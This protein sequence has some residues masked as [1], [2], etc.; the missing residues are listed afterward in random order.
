MRD[1][2]PLDGQSEQMLQRL[3]DE[4]ESSRDKQERGITAKHTDKVLAQRME[5]SLEDTPPDP[6]DVEAVQA[7]ITRLRKRSQ[8]TAR[9][10]FG[11]QE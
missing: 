9:R 4:Y 3:M 10:I 2:L 8:E 11:P 6:D 7:W 1:S 5:A